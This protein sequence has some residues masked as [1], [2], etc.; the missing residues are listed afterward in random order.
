[1][2]KIDSKLLEM[3]RIGISNFIN[4]DIFCLSAGNTIV[5]A[6]FIMDAKT[7]NH[8]PITDNG[9]MGGKLIGMVSR[10][11]IDQL[12]LLNSNEAKKK[13]IEDL[14]INFDFDLSKEEYRNMFH[15]LNDKDDFEKA[16]NLLA[17]K[18]E[19]FTEERY[20]VNA[21]PIIDGGKNLVGIISYK[22]ILRLF[23]P[24]DNEELVIKLNVEDVMRPSADLYTVSED[25]PISECY[26]ITRNESVRTIPVMKGDINSEL[27]GMIFESNVLRQFQNEESDLS[28]G[29]KA[30]DVQL[31]TDVE[32]LDLITKKDNVQKIIHLFLKRPYPPALLVVDQKNK[33]KLVGLLSY[34]DIFKELKTYDPNQ[35]IEEEENE[36]QGG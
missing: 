30:N 11:H 27:K 21:L 7:I 9:K 20:Y 31:M 19:L 18:L 32:F 17:T 13:R 2:N 16:I 4:K 5:D 14:M 10:R 34:I 6:L 29:L 36:D 24:A 15:I 23:I 8:L 3:R 12:I 25:A 1:M 28:L 26:W 33:P 22:D 35:K